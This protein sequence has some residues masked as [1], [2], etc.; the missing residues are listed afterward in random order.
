MKRRIPRLSI[1][2]ATL[3]LPAFGCEL[4]IDTP[5]RA[6]DDASDDDDDGGSG[7]SS[8]LSG[9]DTDGA[10]PNLSTAGDDGS[11]GDDGT[12]GGDSS[13]GIAPS[14]ACAA[15]CETELACDTFYDSES[16]CVEA[17][18]ADRLDS[19]DCGPA[20]DAVNVCLGELSCDAA[21]DFWLAL[22]A[23]GMG[24]DPGDFPCREV[25]FDYAACLD[26]GS[27]V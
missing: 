8:M 14:L 6:D 11:S 26:T 4:D 23:I 2:L 18:E 13:G 24:E 9:G 12:P 19:G 3:A 21:F 1:L 10:G 22:S 20:F 27:G 17:C 25:F 16:E 15:Y 7:G 5:E